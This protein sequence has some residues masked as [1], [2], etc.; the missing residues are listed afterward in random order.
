MD[1]YNLLNSSAI[2]AQNNTLGAA[3]RTPTQILQG[4]LMKIRRADRLL[5]WLAFEAT[6]ATRLQALGFETDN[7]GR[8]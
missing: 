1:I 2:L 5:T 7:A 3:W 4:R 8:E 6:Q